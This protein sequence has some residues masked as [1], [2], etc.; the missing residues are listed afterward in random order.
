MACGYTVAASWQVE[1]SATVANSPEKFK[2]IY[3]IARNI[4]P[5]M[6][7]FI[8]ELRDWFLLQYEFFP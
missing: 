6:V 8:M 7:K 5:I 3:M 2:I 1:E 4:E